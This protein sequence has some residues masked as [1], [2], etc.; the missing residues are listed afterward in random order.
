MGP[1]VERPFHMSTPHSWGPEWISQ[2]LVDA[3]ILDDGERIP[4]VVTVGVV[5]LPNGGGKRAAA[6][7]LGEG[8]P[9]VMFSPR[10]IARIMGA[11][12]SGLL[13]L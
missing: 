10:A 5:R 6:Q 13:T 2:T 4:V 11:L 8:R 7:L 1:S 3:T 9:L 12:R